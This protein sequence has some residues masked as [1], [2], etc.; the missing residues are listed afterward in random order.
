MRVTDLTV[1]VH[2]FSA[3]NSIAS[4]LGLNFLSHFRMELDAQNGVLN[5]EKK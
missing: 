2:D 1:A 3:D 4:L 5:L